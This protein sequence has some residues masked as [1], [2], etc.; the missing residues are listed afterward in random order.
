ML[1][2]SGHPTST[3]AGSE[4]DVFPGS[5]KFMDPLL[6]KIITIVAASSLAEAFFQASIVWRRVRL[7][8]MYICTLLAV[9]YASVTYHRRFGS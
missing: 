4:F 9:H 7:H 5:F 1:P 3:S 2:F 8:D 6:K